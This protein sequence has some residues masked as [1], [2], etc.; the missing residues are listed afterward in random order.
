[1]SDQ[2]KKSGK[3][4]VTSFK[5][6]PGEARPPYRIDYNGAIATPEMF[7]TYSLSR[8]ADLVVDWLNDAY[9]KG[10]AAG[11]LAAIGKFNMV[12]KEA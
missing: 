5:H 8:D 11:E 2:E 7:T 12:G 4:T 1:M 3:V 9:A 10:Y 6:P